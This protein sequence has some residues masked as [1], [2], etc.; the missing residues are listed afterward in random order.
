MPEDLDLDLHRGEVI[1]SR[2]NIALKEENEKRLLSEIKAK[3]SVLTAL[4][5]RCTFELSWRCNYNCKK[6][7]YS[8]LGEGLG[9]F[10]CKP[11][12]MGMGNC[13]ADSRAGLSH[14]EVY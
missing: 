12:G 7:R 2:P 13:R 6:C 4:P 1:M 10:R 3:K 8:S 5:P 11:A 14:Y 9:I